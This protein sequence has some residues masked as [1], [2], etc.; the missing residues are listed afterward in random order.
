MRY[1]KINPMEGGK[2]TVIKLTVDNGIPFNVLHNGY[3]EIN[4][5]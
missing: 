4:E 2:E 3:H 5:G 1:A